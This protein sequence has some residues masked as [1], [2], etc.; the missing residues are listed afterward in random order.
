MIPIYDNI[1]VIAKKRGI[2]LY[3]VERLAGISAGS[4]NHWNRS[5]PS[6][7]TLKKV[8]DVLD[9]DVSLLMKT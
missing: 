4:I 1:K 3:Q 5:S 7:N 9:V 2:P 8:A 6:V